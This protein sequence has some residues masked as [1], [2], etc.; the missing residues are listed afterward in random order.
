MVDSGMAVSF[1][2]FG[3]IGYQPSKDGKRTIYLKVSE[4]FLD[5]NGLEYSPKMAEFEQDA[6][7]VLQS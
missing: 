5:M 2:T 6:T 1:P 4:S 7:I 3:V